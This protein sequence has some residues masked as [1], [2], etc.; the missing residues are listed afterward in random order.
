MDLRSDSAVAVKWVRWRVAALVLLTVVF[1]AEVMNGMGVIAVPYLQYLLALSFLCNLLCLWTDL[2]GISIR[3]SIPEI[4][5][6]V[7]QADAD[8]GTGEQ[9]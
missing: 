1:T 8:A 5:G 2:K 7:G 4:G 9:R 6:L 3:I